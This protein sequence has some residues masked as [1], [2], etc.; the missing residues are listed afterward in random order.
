M[1]PIAV[2]ISFIP[3]LYA[4]TVI[5]KYLAFIEYSYL[6]SFIWKCTS[7]YSHFPFHSLSYQWLILYLFFFNS[8]F[9]PMLLPLALDAYWA[10]VCVDE[11]G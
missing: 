10:F 9:C 11:E 8:N 6:I 5:P 4:M 2:E 3:S 1:L 7:L